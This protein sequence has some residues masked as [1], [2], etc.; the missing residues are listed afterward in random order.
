MPCKWVS[1]EVTSKNFFQ[2]GC[3]PNSRHR[4]PKA[5]ALVR[6]AI[7][8][9]ASARASELVRP[10][11]TGRCQRSNL[12]FFH[13]MSVA[14]RAG[15]HDPRDDRG[16]AAPH[17]KRAPAMYL[18]GGGSILVVRLLRRGRGLR[19]AAMRKGKK[20]PRMSMVAASRRRTTLRRGVDARAQARATSRRPR[21]PASS[22]RAFRS[23]RREGLPRAVRRQA[24]RDPRGARARLRDPGRGPDRRVRQL[25]EVEARATASRSN[26][27]RTSSSTSARGGGGWASSSSGRSRSSRRWWGATRS[28]STARRRTRGSTRSAASRGKRCRWQSTSS[29]VEEN[30]ERG[31]PRA[32][33]KKTL[34]STM[35]RSIDRSF[36]HQE[37]SAPF[38]SLNEPLRPF[39][40]GRFTRRRLA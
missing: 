32:F 12:R 30:R 27:S 10:E 9:A 36:S 4:R 7:A 39:L 28:S 21:L 35:S 11:R 16:V 8:R 2:P 20:P 26:L 1:A 17:S 6:G 23:E 40:V 19:E 37:R 14:A 33:E 18:Q 31:P 29:G 34:R 15:S 24:R 3:A 25:L 22:S 38:D 5:E 13:I